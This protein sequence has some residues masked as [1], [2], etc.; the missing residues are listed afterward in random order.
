MNNSEMVSEN[1]NTIISPYFVINNTDKQGVVIVVTTF[2]LICIWILFIIRCYIRKVN[3]PWK[4]DDTCV[5]AATVL[6]CVRSAVVYVEVHRGYGKSSAILGDLAEVSIGKAIYGDNI[7]YFLAMFASKCS[8]LLL[9]LRMTPKREHVTAI[10]C[11]FAFSAF[12]CIGSILLLT[13]NCNPA[14]PWINLGEECPNIVSRWKGICALDILT[15]FSI[16]VCSIYMVAGLH[17]SWRLKGI[18]LI[19]F[20]I[21]LPTTIFSG[22]HLVA[23]LRE[24]SSLDPILAGAVT[25]AW[26]QIELDFAIAACTFSSLG[27]FLKPFDKEMG[28]SRSGSYQRSYGL[29]SSRTKNSYAMDS[30]G[31]GNHGGKG[32]QQPSSEGSINLPILRPDA[33]DNITTVYSQYQGGK[34][35]SDRVSVDSNDSKKG[36]IMKQVQWTVQHGSMTSDIDIDRN[37]RHRL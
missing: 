9:C 1:P 2:C 17:M 8:V 32:L 11:V 6:S 21:R 28:P 22:I 16:F 30:L 23:V 33:Q 31:S 27:A 7:M 4:W 26:K 36:I 12:W 35:G 15:E 14:H 10:C 25:A 5:A 29:G 13:I 34:S 24:I 37:S 19:A 18:V 3:G 20:A